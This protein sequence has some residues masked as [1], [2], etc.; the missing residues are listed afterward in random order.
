MTLRLWGAIALLLFVLVSVPLG[1]AYHAAPPPD[2]TGEAQ[3]IAN[4]FDRLIRM[5]QQ[6]VFTIAAF[7]SIRAF[8]AA[9]AE[10]RAQRAAVA[11]NE[12][13]AWVAADKRIREALVVDAT[14]KVNLTTA[15]GW[16]DFMGTRSFVRAALQGELAV[17][18]IARDRGEYSTYYAAPIL[19]NSGAV[20]G[21]LVA[22]V[23]AQ[24]L[25]DVLPRGEAWYGALIDEN[26][27]RLDDSGD[28]ARRLMALAPPDP[29]RAVNIL[30][31]ATYGTEIP[32]V[33]ATNAS[34]AQDLLTQGAPEQLTASDLNASAVAARRLATKPWTV[35]VV[36][37]TPAPS[38]VAARWLLP[39]LA[40]LVLA[41]SGAALMSA[42]LGRAVIPRAAQ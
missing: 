36:A 21:A 19:N 34:R 38:S 17:S 13:Q 24:E 15:A 32:R 41:L 10:S 30:N 4:E 40:A 37:P 2:Y 33:R 18:A 28:P 3:R 8:A 23:A 5:R 42:W 25:W 9:D 12:L 7:P 1:L 39:F 29:V 6:Q 35:L 20:A 27:V 22:R 16:N 26:G 14:G 31:Q 11:L